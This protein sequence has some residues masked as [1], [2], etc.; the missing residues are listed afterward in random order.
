MP[1]EMT[2]GV[3]HSK[4]PLKAEGVVTSVFHKLLDMTLGY[5]IGRPRKS[6]LMF[7]LGFQQRSMEVIPINESFTDWAA[8]PAKPSGAVGRFPECH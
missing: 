7:R 6:L 2:N 4:S 8:F 1:L 5:S 3:L